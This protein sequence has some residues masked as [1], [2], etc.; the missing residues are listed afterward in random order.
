VQAVNDSADIINL[1]WGTKW[2]RRPLS[3]PEEHLN[4]LLAIARGAREFRAALLSAT[5]EI[6]LLV[7]GAGND[8]TDAPVSDWAAIKEQP[9]PNFSDRVIVAAASDIND[10]PGSVRTAPFSS[11]LQHQVYE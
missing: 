8:S 9:A 11:I 3:V 5:V 4:D 7:I 2:A 6:P 10:E 1:S